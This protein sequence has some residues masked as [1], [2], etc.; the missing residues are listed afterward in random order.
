MTGGTMNALEFYKKQSLVT[1]PKG[2]AYLLQSFPCDVA[3]IKILLQGLILHLWDGSFYNYQIPL[4]RLFDIETR[5]VEK[6]LEKMIQLDSAEL[7]KERPLDKRIVG[8]CRDYATLFCAILRYQGIPAR[9][10][11]AFSAFYFKD[12]NH[13]EVILE[14]WNEAKKKWCLVDPRVTEPHIKRQKL[15]IDFDLL[16]V[17]HDQ[18]M[19][20][21]LAWQMIR[22]NPERANEFCGGD[23]TKNKG[24]WYVRD[25][26]IQD[27]AALNS[28]EMQLWDIWGL[29]FEDHD[30]E[31]D[32]AQ[33][34]F[35]DHLAELTI[36][37]D[38]HLESIRR[39]YQSDARLKVSKTIKS[40]SPVY[41]GKEITL[42]F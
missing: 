30:I 42:P 36:E 25:R 29:M 32:E 8:S 34:Q 9:T 3:S 22:A 13:D 7:T 38:K 17:P 41:R 4:K 16:D 2:F 31:T 27:F 39:L 21:G 6:M 23:R 14:Y 19:V 12:Y 11:V 1:D 40:F 10:R 35:L 18:L 37:P 28:V 33:L 26:L 24:M 20:A 15:V 5:Y